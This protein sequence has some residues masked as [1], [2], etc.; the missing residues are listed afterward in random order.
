MTTCIVLNRFSPEAFDDPKKF[1][2]LA[3]EVS[4]KI[5]KQCRE[6]VGRAVSQL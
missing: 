4:A 2:G 5:K 6:S 1:K 3:A